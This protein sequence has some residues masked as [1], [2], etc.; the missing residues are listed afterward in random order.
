[1]SSPYNLPDY[2][3]KFLKFKTL[4]QIHGKPSVE[5]LLQLFREVKSNSHTIRTTLG[6]G[7]YGYLAL[8]LGPEMYNSIAIT[9]EFNRPEDPVHFV[10]RS[11]PIPRATL[12]NPDPVAPL[13]T[14]ADIHIQMANY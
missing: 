7:Q 6:G 5:S 11:P 9:T 10:I 2:V 13:L 4:T 12:T 3:T 8:I 14:S 1:M